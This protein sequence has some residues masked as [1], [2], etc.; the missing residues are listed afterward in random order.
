MC[1]SQWKAAACLPQRPQKPAWRRKKVTRPAGA[2]TAPSRGVGLRARSRETGAGHGQSA[3]RPALSGEGHRP[4][5]GSPAW[6]SGSLSV[7]IDRMGAHLPWRRAV[8][9]TKLMSG[10]GGHSA[11]TAQRD[12]A[13]LVPQRHTGPSWRLPGPV[14]GHGPKPT[15]AGLQGPCQMPPPHRPSPAPGERRLKEKFLWDLKPVT[16]PA[17]PVTLL[18]RGQPTP[19]LPQVPQRARR[20][21]T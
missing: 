12:T 17:L 7:P 10:E 9:V 2:S 8:R 13:F 21:W 14:R 16:I 11:L 19:P 5:A 6:A 1:L 18:G 3:H 15:Q 4:G 20:P